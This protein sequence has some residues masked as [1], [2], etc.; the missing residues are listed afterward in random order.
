MY[1]TSSTQ[2]SIVAFLTDFGLSDGYIGVMH[3]V[4]IGIAPHSHLIDITHA[5]PPQQVASGAW[6]L[7]TAYRYFPA[8]TVFLCVVDPGVGSMRRPIALQAGGWYFVGPDNGLFSYVLGEQALQAAVEL[9]NP[10]Y[11]L[12]EVS[13]TFHGRDIFAPA[14][15]HIA[16]GVVLEKLGPQLDAA[17]LVRLPAR[18]ARRQGR[19]VE[20][21]IMHIDHFGNLITNIPLQLVPDLFSASAVTLTFDDVAITERRSFFAGPSHED[22]KPFI[23]GDS[24]GYVAVAIR[25]GNAARALNA[26]L[27]AAITLAIIDEVAR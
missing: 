13:S 3:A 17:S 7:A 15:A 21:A 26:S 9:E 1:H 16:R 22:G 23:Y 27:G 6:V 20:A 25:N 14:A 8:G 12:A 5:I 18:T 19:L 11:R 10:A 24:S 4:V 2:N